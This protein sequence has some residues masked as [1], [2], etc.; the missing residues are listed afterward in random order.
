MV[1]RI[2]D[3][4]TKG[5]F[6][7]SD[8]KD[9]FHAS[10]DLV[11]R[12]GSVI[13]VVKAVLNAD[14]ISGR[15]VDGMVTLARAV[16]GSPLIVSVRTGRSDI[17]DGVMYTRA[18]IPVI[19][20]QTLFDLI[21]EGVPPIVYAAGGGFYAKL[22]SEMLRKTREGGMS[23]GDLAE[24]CGVNRRTIKMYEEGMNT[25]LD[26]ALRLEEG[27]GVELILPVDP[28]SGRGRTTPDSVCMNAPRGLVKDIFDRLQE[29]GYSVDLATRCPFDAVAHDADV[30]VFA[31]IDK[32]SLD[33]HRKAKAM[34]NLSKILDKHSVIFV[35]RLREK[36]NLEGAPIMTN[37]ELNNIESKKRMLELIEERG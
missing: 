10:F 3:T 33:L 29:I 27:L 17:E 12:K 32:K 7:T 25:T 31:G 20:H 4:L 5:E 30:V 1:Q 13:L 18:S 24:M 8:P 16:D 37:K 26:V 23:L 36:M 14:S 28:L 34:A 35:D 22:D 21:I 11:A 6:A 2:Q 19:S 15:A 9:I